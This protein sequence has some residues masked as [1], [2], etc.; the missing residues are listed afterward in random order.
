[1]QQIKHGGRRPRPSS[2]PTIIAA[3]LCVVALVTAGTAWWMLRP[4]QKDTLEHLAQPQSSSSTLNRDKAPTP[5]P[6]KSQERQKAAGDSPAA[7]ASRA[8][9]TMSLDERAG[10]LIMAPMFA[11]GNPADL[12]ALISTRHVGS[13]VLIGNWNNGTAAA[14]TAADALQSYAPSGNQLIVST[15]QEG[16]QVQHLKGS[17]FDTMPSAVAQGQMSADT[18]RSSAKTWGGQL[19]QAG[20]NIDLA[21]VLGTV[22]VKRSSNAPIGALNRDFGLDSNG[23]AQH[24]I[25][26]VEGMRDAGVGATVKHYPGLGAVTGNT[27]FTTEGILDTTTTLDD[28]E[29]GAFNTTIKQAKPAMVMM[30]LATYQRIDSS[31]PA[32]FSSKIIDGTLRGSVGYDGVVISDSLSAAAVSGIATKDLGVR[33]VDAGGDLACI[34]DT[35]YVTPILDGIIAR[36]QSDP[37]F[38]KKVT[39]S[40]TRVMTL[41]YQ[42]GLAK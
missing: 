28:E 14:K 19:K 39:A 7:K 36:A 35:S 32:A 13:V 42:M 26:F 27:D 8:I 18:L 23:N 41:K 9:A 17:G 30:S 29:I 38:A 1:M 22:Q 6:Q 10:Q 21:P 40:A 31:A 5:K 3:M 2:A 34:G 11:G 16:G 12:S 25:A 20:I 15:D 24:G 33:L 4:Q 37:A